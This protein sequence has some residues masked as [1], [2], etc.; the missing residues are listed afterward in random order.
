MP[1]IVPIYAAILGLIFA[2]LSIR[3]ARLRKRLKIAIGD[4]GNRILQRAG[5]VHANFAEYVPFSLLLLCFV[6][7]N[8]TDV[9]IV[10]AMCLTLVV[11][12]GLHAWGVS[13]VREKFRF[14]ITAI[15]LQIGVLASAALLILSH[16]IRVQLS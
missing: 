7:A 2:G 6:E 5:R 9:R 11:A 14:R 15:G 16:A 10:H 1:T 12:R 8:G 13:H 4:A 3:T